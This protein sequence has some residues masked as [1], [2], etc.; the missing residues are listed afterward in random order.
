VLSCG[1]A[2]LI[3]VALS[4][5]VEGSGTRCA[6]SSTN[7]GLIDVIGASRSRIGARQLH[8]KDSWQVRLQVQV[9]V[10][11]TVGAAALVIAIAAP[12]LLHEPPN[13]CW[14]QPTWVLQPADPP[15]VGGR[16][17]G[18][19]GLVVCARRAQ[20]VRRIG[21]HWRPG[22]GV[23]QPPQHFL[24]AR[25]RDWILQRSHNSAAWGGAT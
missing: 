8:S 23:N 13:A 2:S 7:C 9:L 4:S 25:F 10:R 12:K 22:G 16:R 11:F 5:Q 3:E 15:V 19:A 6:V 24:A 21:A 18:F 1:A 14:Y 20:N 17:A